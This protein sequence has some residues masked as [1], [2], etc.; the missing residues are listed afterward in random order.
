MREAMKI[1]Q[2]L[3]WLSYGEALE[4]MVKKCQRWSV[5][6]GMESDQLEFMGKWFDMDRARA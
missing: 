3:P 4:I 5:V 1:R 6:V 2:A